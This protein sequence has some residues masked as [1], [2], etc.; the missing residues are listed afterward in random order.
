MLK[1]SQFILEAAD[2]SELHKFA[3]KEYS[4]RNW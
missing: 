4:K 2:H 3:R 1:F